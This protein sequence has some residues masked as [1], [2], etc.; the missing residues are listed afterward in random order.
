M[1]GFSEPSIGG[2]ADTPA[3]ADSESAR[4]ARN[5]AADRTPAAVAFVHSPAPA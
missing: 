4:A 3:D 2:R 5:G 1:S